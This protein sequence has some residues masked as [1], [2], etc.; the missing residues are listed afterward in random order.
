MALPHLPSQIRAMRIVPVL[1]A[2]AGAVVLQHGGSHN[3]SDWG[4]ATSDGYACY[5]GYTLGGWMAY[6]TEFGHI[7]RTK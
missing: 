1:I 4:P 3:A 7:G 2:V 5:R 6:L